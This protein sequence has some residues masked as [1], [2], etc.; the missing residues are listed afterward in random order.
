MKRCTRQETALSRSAIYIIIRRLDHSRVRS[1]P[2]PLTC[3][4]S[5]VGGH[6]SIT[7][8]TDGN[9]ITYIF[10]TY[11]RCS[12]AKNGEGSAPLPIFRT[13]SPLVDMLLAPTIDLFHN[14]GQISYSSVL[15]LTSLSSLATTSKF[16]KNFCFKMKAVGLINTNEKECKG[17]RPL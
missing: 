15:M 13:A 7:F 6:D 10:L 17:G 12:R 16:Q 9:V 1:A 11:S 2:S 5:Y 8:C 3:S 4:V 14:G